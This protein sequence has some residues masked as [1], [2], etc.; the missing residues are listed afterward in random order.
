M[1][2]QYVYLAG[3]CVMIGVA[4]LCLPALYAPATVNQDEPAYLVVMPQALPTLQMGGYGWIYS[5]QVYQWTGSSWVFRGSAGASGGTIA[6]VALQPV[7]F[8]VV[9]GL[10]YY[11]PSPPTCTKALQITRVYIAITGEV[12]STLMTPESC[13]SVYPDVAWLLLFTYNWD[14]A[15]KPAAGATYTVTLTYQAYY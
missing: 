13:P 4:A 11:L 8:D 3:L 15:G 9:T 2:M 7:H 6:L 5:L 12:S 14:V 1:K 10:Y